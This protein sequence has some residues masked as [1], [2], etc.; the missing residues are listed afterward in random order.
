MR[1][2]TKVPVTVEF[3]TAQLTSE[4]AFFNK[5]QDAKLVYDTMCPIEYIEERNRWPTYPCPGHEAIKYWGLKSCYD[6]R[7][8]VTVK[9]TVNLITFN[10]HK[11]ERGSYVHTIE[12][13][14]DYKPLTIAAFDT[15]VAETF[16]H[17]PSQTLNFMLGQTTDLPLE[18]SYYAL[19]RL[20]KELKQSGLIS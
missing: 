2:I 18:E 14:L 20:E 5:I 3:D 17:L 8:R 12:A 15:I 7:Q 19:L 4:L 9:L 16:A 13:M 6:F 10:E 1:K 11:R